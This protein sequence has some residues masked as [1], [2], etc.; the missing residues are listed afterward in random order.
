MGNNVQRYRYLDRLQLSVDVDMLKFNPGGSVMVT[1]VLTQVP[2]NRCTSEIL[3]DGA[4][5]LEM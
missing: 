5:I 3:V 4:R 1:I 2:E